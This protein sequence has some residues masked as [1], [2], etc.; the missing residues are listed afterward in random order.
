MRFRSDAL[1]VSIDDDGD[2]DD[3]DDDGDDGDDDDGGDDDDDEQREKTMD[4]GQWTM[5]Y[6]FQNRLTR[7]NRM[8]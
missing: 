5:D 4:N 2:D 3:D 8:N 1:S 6:C 7:Y